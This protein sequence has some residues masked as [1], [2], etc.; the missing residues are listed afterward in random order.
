MSRLVKESGWS[1]CWRGRS[2]PGVR[3]MFMMLRDSLQ[4]RFLTVLS[5]QK[6]GTIYLEASAFN[7]KLLHMTRASL[8]VHIKSK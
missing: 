2:V 7:S 5:N 3:K 8:F 4:V 1:R 6:H